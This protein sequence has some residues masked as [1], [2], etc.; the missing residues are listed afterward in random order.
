M[1]SD[2]GGNSYLD[3]L[4]VLQSA[5]RNQLQAEILQVN[6]LSEV[7]QDLEEISNVLQPFT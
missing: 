7:Q 3:K 2:F 1:E 6:I 4:H 5:H